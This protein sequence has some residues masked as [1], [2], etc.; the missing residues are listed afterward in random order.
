L[1]AFLEADALMRES[2][3]PRVELEIA[4]V[5]A[6]RR[7]KPQE[8]EAVLKRVDEAEARL[9]QSGMAGPGPSS[10]GV[11]GSLLGATPAAPAAPARPPYDARRA[12]PPSR[13]ASGAPPRDA[14]APPPRDLGGA[15]PR[16]GG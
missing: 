15:A 12:P 8:L 3:H 1:R 11:Q 7:P 4:A 16:S 9:R 2:P 14:D 6:T 13:E 10:G 5:R